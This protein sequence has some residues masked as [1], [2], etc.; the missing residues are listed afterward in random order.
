MY[1]CKWLP[2]QK[3]ILAIACLGI[4]LSTLGSGHAVLL[5]QCIAVQLRP[6]HQLKR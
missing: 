5:S 4:T 2:L 6:G 1:V 3:K